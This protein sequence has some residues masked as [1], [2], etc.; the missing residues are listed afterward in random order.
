M[1]EI[2]HKYLRISIHKRNYKPY[3]YTTITSSQDTPQFVSGWSASKFIDWAGN[4]YESVKGYIIKI[5]ES[6]THEE[7]AYKSCLGIFGFERII[8]SIKFIILKL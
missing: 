3:V 7:Q 4:I 1:V 8:A 2:Y 5:I 6:R